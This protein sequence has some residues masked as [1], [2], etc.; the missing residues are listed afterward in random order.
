MNQSDDIL[1]KIDRAVDVLAQAVSAASSVFIVATILT[2]T[3]YVIVR[4]LFQGGWVFV[5]EWSGY[6]LLF[7]A[8]CSCA[9]ALRTGSH[10][11]VDLVTRHLRKKVRMWLTVATSLLGLAVLG[12]LSGIS[13]ERVIYNAQEFIQS[14]TPTLTP[15]WIPYSFI[16]LGLCVF[17]LAML[18]YLVFSVR[19]AVRGEE[20]KKPTLYVG[21]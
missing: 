1:G 14:T 17:T 19:A 11:N 5:E 16:A 8:Y 21:E 7:I 3:A 13:I 2:V 4:E 15:L 18:L 20:I 6:A 12:Y 10:I 9:L